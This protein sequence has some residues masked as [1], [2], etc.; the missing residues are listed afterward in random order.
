MSADKRKVSTDALETLGTIIGPNEKRDAIHLAVIPAKASEVLFP[1]QAIT[2]ED[3]LARGDKNGIGIVDPFLSAP[4]ERGET[5]WMVLR[6]RLITSLRHVWTH[7]AL[8]D[9]PMA[10]A[11][12]VG[13]AERKAVSEKWLREFCETT[14][15]PTYDELIE[16]MTTGSI[17]DYDEAC[18][19]FRDYGD[20]DSYLFFGGVD[21]H[22]EI[23]PAFWTH[24]EIVTGKT[25]PN[26]PTHF[27]CSC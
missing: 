10:E 2:Y 9:E 14:D 26:K 27:S 19:D 1:S 12:Q 11:V 16:L 25:F 24:L 3:G 22:G 15:C 20:G 13:E 17:K 8:P 7:P 21:A 6:P 5:F 18:V 23:P 4:V